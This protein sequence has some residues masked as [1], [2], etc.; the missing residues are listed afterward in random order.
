MRKQLWV[1][2]AVLAITLAG[3][4]Q[5]APDDFASVNNT[6]SIPVSTPTAT[7]QIINPNAQN[8]ATATT[9]AIVLPTN[10]LI[11]PTETPVDAVVVPP[12]P[13]V[14]L[15]QPQQAFTAT[16]TVLII[17]PVIET[18]TPS[19]VATNTPEQSLLTVPTATPP[20][21][22]T[23]QAPSQLVIPTATPTVGQ[24]TPIVNTSG[25]ITPT[26]LPLPTNE[27]CTYIVKGGDNLFRIALNNNV[28][29]AELLAVNSLGENS[30][31]QPGQ[32][33]QLPN[34]TATPEAITSND[35]TP[36]NATQDPN[37][38]IHRVASGETLGAIARRYG[39][40]IQQIVTA[41][42]LANP[43]RLSVGQELIIPK[44]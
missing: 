8:D 25:I 31:I 41:N 14:A 34:C 29:L 18:N 24:G 9:Q 11:I 40:T 6:N 21:I 2:G 33:L 26:A 13:T 15:V 22:I 27:A 30:V 7:V 5:Q 4:Y 32:A 12:T 1:A 19:V 23:P 42:N 44:P 35:G 37:V 38:T 16:P 10:E 36:P 17:Q 43:D 28:T 20:S 39:V 3:C